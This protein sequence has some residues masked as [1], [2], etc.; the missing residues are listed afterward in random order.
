MAPPSV[1]PRSAGERLE[2]MWTYARDACSHV[3]GM[4]FSEFV[5]SD[6]HQQ[7]TFYAVG[8]VGEAASHVGQEVRAANPDIPWRRIVGM[9][10]HLFH[11]YFAIDIRVVWRTVQQ[12][13]PAL[14]ARLE[15]LIPEQA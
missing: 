9:R 7:S 8:T 1:Q 14:I 6:L 5:R 4:T 12:D 13:L 15:P 10:N 11:A 3:E 2:D